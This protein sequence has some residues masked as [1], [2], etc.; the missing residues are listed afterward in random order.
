MIQRSQSVY[1]VLA[2]ILLGLE[3]MFTDVFPWAATE[4]V[5]WFSP[6]VLGLFTVAAIGSFGSIFLYKDRKR[7][8][9]L[10]VLLQYLTLIGLV[11]LV[12]ANSMAGTLPGISM[13]NAA[14]SHWGALVSPIMA[15]L[16]FLMARRGIAKDIA[17]VRSMDRLR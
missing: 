13:S 11:M 2:T 1:L 16:M 14:F 17:L 4:Q 5:A 8:K 12:V 6:A 10:V 3:Y 7:Q 15:Y 9:G